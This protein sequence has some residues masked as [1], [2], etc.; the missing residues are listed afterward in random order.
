MLYHYLP[1]Y[2]HIDI[3]PSTHDAK[4]PVLVCEANLSVCLS[5]ARVICANLFI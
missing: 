4:T 5:F 3:E 2:S 1:Q